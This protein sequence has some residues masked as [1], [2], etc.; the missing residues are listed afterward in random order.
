MI[1]LEVS[2]TSAHSIAGITCDDPLQAQLLVGSV[3]YLLLDRQL[4]SLENDT[5][6]PLSEDVMTDSGM[7]KVAEGSEL[8][9]P[10]MLEA[11]GKLTILTAAGIV[12]YEN[13][14]NDKFD[15]YPNFQIGAAN[16]AEDLI[17]LLTGDELIM[18]NSS[19]DLVSSCIL[20]GEEQQ[21]MVNVGWG[22][23]E[24]QFNGKK[25][26]PDHQASATTEDKPIK[27]SRR[28]EI[29]WRGDDEYFALL[30]PSENEKSQLFVYS[31]D[32]VLCNK[33]EPF[34]STGGLSWGRW[35]AVGANREVLFF[36]KNCLRRGSF[37][38]LILRKA[39]KHISQARKELSQNSIGIQVKAL[40]QS[41]WELKVIENLNQFKFGRLVTFIGTISFQSTESNHS[42]GQR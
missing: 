30:L 41:W 22:R 7:D 35:I 2:T 1:N 23:R 27:V 5:W 37:G 36:E 8:V 38:I 42:N 26:E 39:L 6:N 18:V 14:S 32:L 10:S 13:I 29:A 33:S 20:G 34:T 28:P 4:F 3:P 40:W 31:Q 25:I 24:T 17:V 15:S 11:D 12:Q 9:V 16:H 21:A 19:L